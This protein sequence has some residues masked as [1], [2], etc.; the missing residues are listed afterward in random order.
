MEL[1][2]EESG[3]EDVELSLPV[4]AESAAIDAD[5]V[6]ANKRASSLFLFLLLML[7]IQPPLVLNIFAYS[8]FCLRAFPVLIGR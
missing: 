4:Q 7:R 5:I 8:F 6:V 2:L 3:V 1:P